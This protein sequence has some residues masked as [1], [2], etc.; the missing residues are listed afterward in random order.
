MSTWI[1]LRG[2]MREARHWGDFPATFCRAL[3]DADVLTPNLPGNGRLNRM[4]SPVRVADM[5]DYCR[6]ELLA[7]GV[8]PPYFLLAMSLGAMVAA[9]WAARHPDEL[10]G[11]VLINTSLRPFSPFFHRLRPQTYPAVL[12]LALLGG[13]AAAWEQTILALTSRRA[14]NAAALLAAW[15]AWRREHPVSRANAWR[16]LFAAGR[17]R[18]PAARPAPP[19]LLLASGQDRLVDP[20]CSRRLAQRWNAAYAEHP[21]A[22][23]DLPLDDGAWVARQ[24]RDWLPAAR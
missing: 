8:R 21:D 7:Q 22:G 1:F 18:A 10:R 13:S 3:P 9:D 4:A 12:K 5:A 24:V 14:G 19:L 23:H 6:A 17:Y 15:T 2:L 20:R 16:Q 11:C